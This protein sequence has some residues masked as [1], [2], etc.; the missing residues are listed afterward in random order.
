MSIDDEILDKVGRGMLFPL[1]PLAK[2]ETAI[3]AMFVAE[4][5]WNLLQSPEGDDEWEQRIGE[6]QAD[7]ER[8]ITDSSLDPKYLFLLYPSRDAV[9]EIRSVGSDPSIRVLGLFPKQDV[10]VA[11]NHALRR[12]LGGWQSRAWKA[13]KRLAGTIWRQLFPTYT[14]IKTINVHDVITGALDGKYFKD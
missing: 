12:D 2:G 5:L 10:F 8:F 3:R 1:T 11:T 6:L 9:W 14:P 13:V 7:L 4:D